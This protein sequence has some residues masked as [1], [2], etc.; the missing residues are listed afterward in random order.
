MRRLQKGFT[1][2]ELLIVVAIIAILAAIAVPNFL[3]AQVRAKVSRAKADM[4]TLATGIEAYTVDW[5]K[6]QPAANMFSQGG[7]GCGLPTGLPN[8]VWKEY[9]YSKLT[10]PVAYL[11]SIPYDPFREKGGRNDRTQKADNS[12]GLY[13]FDAY[14]CEAAWIAQPTW[15]AIKA[16]RA[17][18]NWALYSVGPSRN[19]GSGGSANIV[20]GIVYSAPGGV[21][22]A[23]DPSN[24]TVSYG[25]IIRTNKGEFGAPPKYLD[26]NGNPI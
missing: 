13:E 10:T 6:H 8:G 7:R 22:Y 19:T 24:G 16:F 2:I 14:D 3:E 15:P 25:Y 1:L 21:L 12:K 5:N 11:T 4:R 17:G 18:Y 23:Y 20:A 9:C 26:P